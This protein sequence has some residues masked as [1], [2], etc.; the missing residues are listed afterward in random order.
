MLSVRLD[1]ETEKR[2]RRLSKKTGRSV[3]YYAR[4]AVINLLED[5]EDVYMAEMVLA[6]NERVWSHEEVKKHLGFE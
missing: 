3:S 1:E 4:E 5:M 6:R 2:L